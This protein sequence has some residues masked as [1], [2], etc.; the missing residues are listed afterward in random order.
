MVV[1][2]K[3]LLG[4]ARKAGVAIIHM[5]TVYK[6]PLLENIQRRLGWV[7]ALN[8]VEAKITGTSTAG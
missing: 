3:R 4:F 2:R 7:L 5:T 1:V 6:T 8:E